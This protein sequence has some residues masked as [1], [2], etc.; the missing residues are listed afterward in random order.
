VGRYEPRF[1]GR[2]EAATSSLGPVSTT[3]GHDHSLLSREL[4][5]D[6]LQKQLAEEQDHTRRLRL[7]VERLRARVIL[8]ASGELCSRCAAEIRQAQRQATPPSTN[9]SL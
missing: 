8:S 7:D 5:I 4:R 6:L 1:N 9:A 3:G 2:T